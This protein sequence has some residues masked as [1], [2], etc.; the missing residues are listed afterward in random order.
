MEMAFLDVNGNE[1]GTPKVLDL[2]SVQ[3]NDNV[4]REHILNGRAPSGTVSVRVTAGM[5]DG[6]FTNGQQTAFF[7]DFALVAVPEPGT[8]L[9]VSMA[10]AHAMVYRRRP[11]D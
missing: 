4:W 8:F 9:L 10:I 6:F 1:I 7:D 11:S 5:L 2:R 3:T